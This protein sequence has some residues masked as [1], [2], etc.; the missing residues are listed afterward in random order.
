L[1]TLVGVIKEGHVTIRLEP[2]DSP[3]LEETVLVDT[4][5]TGDPQFIEEVARDFLP[6]CDLILFVFSAAS[7]LDKSDVPLLLELHQR[8]PFVP[9]HFVVTRTDELRTNADAPLTEENLD[10]RKTEQFLNTVVT[11]V[12]TLLAPQVYLTTSI[13]LIDNRSRFRIQQLRDFLYARG[14]S[15]NPQAHISM[16]LNKLHF[17]RSGAKSLRV[18]FSDIV[19]KKLIELTKIVEAAKKNIDKY[20]QLVQISNS[21]LT[22][23]WM[24]HSATINSAASKTIEIVQPL[25]VLPQQYNLFQSV[26]SKRNDLTNDLYRSAKYHGGSISS[27]IEAQINGAL[28]QHLYTIQKQISDTPLPDLSADVHSSI[29]A[30]AVVLPALN[31][32]QSAS[33]LQRQAFE[34][35][36]A[37]ANALRDVAADYRRALGLLLEQLGQ[38]AFLIAPERAIKAATSSLKVDLNNFF[39]NVELYRSGVFSHTTKESIATLGIG[40]QLD[41]LE[42]EFTDDD[43]ETYAI[44]AS[45]DL[46]PGSHEL[47]QTAENSGRDITQNAQDAAEE[48]RAIRVEKP[49]DNQVSLED[50]INSKR[51][52]FRTE[53]RD[54][55]QSE[56]DRFCSGLSLT[57]ASLIVSAKTKYDSSLSLLRKATRRRY[58]T[59]FVITALVYVCIRFV[60]SHS[61]RPAP[62]SFV[63][64]AMLNLGCGVLLEVIVL[65][66]VKARENVPKLLT[67]T[68]EDIQVKLKEDVRHEIDT[69]L[70][71]LVFNSLNE[72]VIATRLTKIYVL[73]LD[74]PSGA[75]QARAKDT[76]DSLRKV[77]SSY[78]ALRTAYA[79]VVE[80]VRQDASQYFV[81]SSRNLSVLNGVASRIKEKAIEPSFDLLAATREE[82]LLVKTDVDSVVFD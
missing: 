2:V 38:R 55:L 5:G 41:T 43:K 52:A 46:F 24:E 28:Q 13:T 74:L 64:E 47:V 75:W 29:Q 14:N 82:L 16:H 72:Q 7:P 54:Q 60:Y 56:V 40:Q 26:V 78:S 63:G 31:E 62:T 44:T 65:A 79:K 37:E 18:F 15:S 6:I 49:E 57:I 58:A 34:L 30:L 53:L 67:Q 19:D 68:R 32:M 73:A 69:Q 76:L 81:D 3:F 27:G 50:A 23:T 51:E 48:A 4:P 71:A 11:R 33:S 25:T 45:N 80:Q 77:F 9:I 59:A 10:A 1:L 21:N 39:Q 42:T 35:R 20:Q 8:L 70:S 12:N 66:V 61:G 22:K 36:E 17:Y